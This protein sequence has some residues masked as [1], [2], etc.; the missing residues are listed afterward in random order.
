MLALRQAH[1]TVRSTHLLLLG[2]AGHCDFC[3]LAV[4][5]SLATWHESDLGLSWMNCRL[6]CSNHPGKLVFVSKGCEFSSGWVFESWPSKLFSHQSAYLRHKCFALLQGR[7]VSMAENRRW[8]SSTAWRRVERGLCSRWH[9]KYLPVYVRG[10][11]RQVWPAS[12]R[13]W[14]MCRI[15]RPGHSQG[16]R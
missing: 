5:A 12:H 8:L 1:S 3:A 11:S 2:R 10:C 14:G 9:C 16:G 15:A 6:G 7:P 13:F 4:G